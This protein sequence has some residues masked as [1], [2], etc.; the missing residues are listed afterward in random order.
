MSSRFACPSV[1]VVD[2]LA[3]YVV[4]SETDDTLEESVVVCEDEDVVILL[5]LVVVAVL[6]SVVGETA[7]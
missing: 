6:F 1:R 7:V 3:V 2:E 4:M 5:G